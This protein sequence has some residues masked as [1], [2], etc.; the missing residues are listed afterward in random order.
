MQETKELIVC[1]AMLMD[2]GH[3]VIGIRHYSPDMR[4]TLKRIYGKGFRMFGR[5]IIKPY[6]LRVLEQ[7]F[8]TNLGRFV[9]RR[10]AWNIAEKNGQIRERVGVHSEL[11]SENLY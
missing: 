1:A 6:H 4:E 8:I 11:Y 7:G 2:D 5:I 9:G 3:I 10:E